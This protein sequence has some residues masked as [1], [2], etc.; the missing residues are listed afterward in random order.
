[1]A[2]L[3][4]GLIGLGLTALPGATTATHQLLDRQP[5]AALAKAGRLG[6]LAVAQVTREGAEGLAAD[7]TI[8]LVSSATGVLALASRLLPDAPPATPQGCA[9]A[10]ASRAPEAAAGCQ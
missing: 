2:T 1:L 8:G 4:L 3:W 9:E 5:W 10:E 7:A 6:A